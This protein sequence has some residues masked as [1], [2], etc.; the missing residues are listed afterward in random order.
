MHGTSPFIDTAAVEAW[1]AW[2]RWRDRDRLHDLSIEA[3]WQRVIGSLTGSG[4]PVETDLMDACSSWRLLLDERI[5]ATAGTPSANWPA[6]DLVAAV[7]APM[8]VRR[9]F[10][11]HA[12]V[13]V[14]AL[15]QTAKLAVRALDQAVLL[16]HGET[17]GNVR[18]RIGIVGMADALALLGARYDAAGAGRHAG[19]VCSAIAEG[20]FEASI[21]MTRGR[22]PRRMPIAGLLERAIERGLPAELVRDARRRGLRHAGLTAIT[23]QPRLALLANNVANA[24]DPLLGEN[25]VHRIAVADDTRSVRSSGY[26]LI[27]GRG[28]SRA[29]SPEAIATIAQLGIDAQLALRAAAQRWVDEPIVYPLALARAPEEAQWRSMQRLAREGG[30]AEPSWRSLDECIEPIAAAVPVQMQRIRANRAS[31]L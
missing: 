19:Q 11:A 24:L 3:T 10:T 17:S 31:P 1:D 2:F 30:L 8:F 7:N 6:S 27:V 25:H 26:A 4:S 18:L 20:C 14:G 29:S 16:R 21:G 23:S 9:R 28:P 22:A 5:L 12:H 13:D 15:A